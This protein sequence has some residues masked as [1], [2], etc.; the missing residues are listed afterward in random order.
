[1]K[2]NEIEWVIRTTNLNFERPGSK[3]LNRDYQ[4]ADTWRNRLD[5]NGG[6]TGHLKIESENGIESS[7]DSKF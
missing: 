2:L 4:K 7:E 1:M 6:T 3:N 5:H